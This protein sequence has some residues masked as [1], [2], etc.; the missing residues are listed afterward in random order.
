ML[1]YSI[2][3]KKTKKTYSVKI[4]KLLVIELMPFEA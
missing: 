3:A 1:F 4:K 2:Q